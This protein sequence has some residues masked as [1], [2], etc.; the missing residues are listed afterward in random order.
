MGIGIANLV[1]GRSG[2]EIHDF[3]PGG[4]YRNTRPLEYLDFC[5]SYR[6]RGGNRGGSEPHSGGEQF[7][8]ALGFRTARNHVFPRRDPTLNVDGF[9][10][11]R[12]V[13]HHH[14]CVSACGNGGP[15]HNFCAFALSDCYAGNIHSS[16][17]FRD[18]FQP[19][20]NGSDINSAHRKSIASRPGKRR[21]ITIG[22]DGLRQHARVRAG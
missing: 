9:A 15:G 14:D 19:Y 13:F 3:V 8:S 20:W 18:N 4:K 1:S 22:G 21:K 16:L 2:R 7:L 10:V 17:D 5:C 6:C 11:P 12:R